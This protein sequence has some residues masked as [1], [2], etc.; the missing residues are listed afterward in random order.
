M[1][2]AER[3]ATY[4]PRKDSR[5]YY[6]SKMYEIDRREFTVLSTAGSL[7]WVQFDDGR[8]DS[9]IWCFPDC[10]NKAHHWDGKPEGASL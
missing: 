5:G 3:W 1:E 6:E 9:F 2:T 7:C 10:L 4:R 8:V